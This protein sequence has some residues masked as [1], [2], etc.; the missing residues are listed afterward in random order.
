MVLFEIDTVRSVVP[1]RT[2]GILVTYSPGHQETDYD[3]QYHSCVSSIHHIELDY[4]SSFRRSCVVR[5]WFPS[6]P[7]VQSNAF[8]HLCSVTHGLE[9]GLLSLVYATDQ[10]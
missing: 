8:L 1:V 4:L 3:R 9:D 5:C 2:N 6:V 7:F 10:G